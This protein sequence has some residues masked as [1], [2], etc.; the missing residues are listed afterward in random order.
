MSLSIPITGGVH[1]NIFV[2]G[3]RVCK[4]ATQ[5]RDHLNEHRGNHPTA[6]RRACSVEHCYLSADQ[7]HRQKKRKTTWRKTSHVGRGKTENQ[8]GPEK[9]LGWEEVIMKW[10]RKRHWENSPSF[11]A[12]MASHLMCN[13][14]WY[15]TR[16]SWLWQSKE[17]PATLKALTAH[18]GVPWV[19]CPA[20]VEVVADRARSKHRALRFRLSRTSDIGMGGGDDNVNAWSRDV[21]R[22]DGY[23]SGVS[24]RWTRLLVDDEA[25][26]PWQRDGEVRGYSDGLT[27]GYQVDD[28]GIPA[29]GGR[30]AAAGGTGVRLHDIG[31]NQ[32]TQ[33]VQVRN[34]R[35]RLAASA[36]ARRGTFQHV[37]RGQ[38]HEIYA[39]YRGTQIPAARR[40][41]SSIWYWGG[42]SQR[43][44]PQGY[45][46][47]AERGGSLR[48]AGERAES[49]NR[50]QTDGNRCIFLRVHMHFPF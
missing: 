8:S 19:F 18:R 21:Q 41:G 4:I 32:T 37:S 26:T 40:K 45:G 7:Q 48:K 46:F 42:D 31:G 27:C 36:T 23:R 24:T 13:C 50:R 44:C 25:N 30:T 20:D 29:R 43:I 5:E 39:G 12:A 2:L 11:Q 1:K 34:W 16:R 10:N 47:T 14:P 33:Q 28:L 17:Y 15:A 22:F 38:A 9:T 6:R 3:E 49:Q 35:L